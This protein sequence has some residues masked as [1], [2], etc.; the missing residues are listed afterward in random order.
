MTK[1]KVF[2]T[3][4]IFPEAIEEIKKVAEVDLWTDDMPPSREILLERSK[5]VDGILCHLT[6]GIDG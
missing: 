3:R 5:G 1:P 6:D 4:N 2:I